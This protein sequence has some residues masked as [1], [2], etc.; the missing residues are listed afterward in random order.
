MKLARLSALLIVAFTLGAAAN[1]WPSSV[2]LSNNDQLDGSLESLST[3][4]LLWKSSLLEKPTSF[5]LKNV[6]DL[7]LVAAQPA[8]KVRSQASVRMT[9]G[10]VIH[11]QLAAVTD[12]AVELD[13]WFAGRLKLN[14]PMI[15]DLRISDCPDLIYGGPKALEDWKLSGDK[16]AW[17]YQNFSLRANASGSIAKNVDLPDACS[18]AFD[19]GWGSLLALKLIIFSDDL[20]SEHPNSGYEITIQNRSVYLRSCKTQKFLGHTLNAVMLQE[21]QKARIEV[22]TSLKS[23]KICLYVDGRIVDIW[24][25]PNADRN[26]VGQGLHFISQ[27]E[28]PLQISR[29]EVSAWDGELEQIP[30]PRH[31]GGLRQFENQAELDSQE[32]PEQIPVEKTKTLR[33]ELRNGDSIVGQILSIIDDIMTVKTPFRE[34]KLPVDALRTVAL[35]PA[36]FERCKREN[37]DIR[38]WFPDGSFMVFR[39]DEVNEGQLTGYSQHFGTARFNMAAFNRIEFNIY[40]PE[41]EAIRKANSLK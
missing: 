31:L 41:F 2:L 5:L 38:G 32:E 35:K 22:R 36:E 33:I 18:V 15:A 13:T 17:T 7:N 9:N 27:N 1:E 34:V 14:R 28:F 3:E 26:A 37:G 4:R 39:L 20:T 25:D 8:T 10:D 12:E 29:I 16:T 30:D 11:G 23:G 21:N 6:L 24:T 40:K 19:V